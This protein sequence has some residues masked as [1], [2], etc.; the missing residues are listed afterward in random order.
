VRYRYDVERQKR[1]KTVELIVDEV[2][3]KP[4][5]RRPKANEI[6]AVWTD[7]NEKALQQRIRQAGGKWDSKNAVWRLR[8]DQVRALGLEK[9]IR[10]P[11]SI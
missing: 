9:R 1:Y 10:R 11:R 7:W 3:W 6:I 5:L 8:Y 4:K 2:D